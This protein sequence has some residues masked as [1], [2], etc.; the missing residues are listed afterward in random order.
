MTP[1]PG[2]P[3]CRFPLAIPRAGML[4]LAALGSG[5]A[6]A[7]SPGSIPWKNPKALSSP[8]VLTHAGDPAADQLA[9]LTTAGARH[10]VVMF[11]GPVSDMDRATLRL[12]GVTLL[13]YLGE[14]AF[15]AAVDAAQ[16]DA[17]I[18]GKVGGLV[19]AQTIPLSGKIHPLLE[20]YVDGGRGP[21]WATVGVSDD[22][23]DVAGMYVLFHSDVD[24]GDGLDA[25]EARGGVVR[26]VLNSING[27]V[28][29]LPLSQVRP[30]A[31]DDAV[32]WIEHALPQMSETNDSNRARVQ[33]D[34]AQAPPYSLTGAGVKVLVY[35]AGTARATHQDFNGRLTTHDNSGQITHATHVAGTIGGSGT[36]NPLYRGMAPGC[37]LISYGFQWSGGGIFLYSNP[38]DIEADYG[39]AINVQGAVISN[40]SIGSNTESNGFPCSIQGD[41]GVTDVLID[42]IVR[43]SL[44]GGPFRIIWAA[45]NERQG[46]NCDIE[47]Y[48]DYY[49]MAPPACAKNH[50]TV[51]ALNSNNDSMT[52][53]SSWGPTDDGR[54]K[55][56]ISAPGCEVG[57][58]GGVTS[59]SASSN[60]SYASLCGTS[61][62]SPTTC[63]VA[64]LM[65]QDYRVQ[66]PAL[67]DP[68]N[69]TLKIL[70]A[71][72]A[73][74]L[75]NMGPDYQF[76]YGS[77][78]AVNAINF[79]RTGNF[80]EDEI[81]QGG[82]ATFKVNATFA[83]PLKVTI[84]WD[85]YP[86]TANAQVALINDLD[87][88]AISPSQQV[89]YPWTLNPLN[90]SAPAVRTVRN[91]RDN[92]EQIF[93]DNP[94]TGEWTIEVIG[95]NVPEGPQPFSICASPDLTM[96]GL[97]VN[98]PGAAP[99]TLAPGVSVNVPVQIQIAGETLVPG[100]PT[101]HFRYDGGAWL[102]QPLA[103]L[104]GENY[105]ATLP[106]PVCGSTPQFYVSAAGSDS[107][108]VT[109]PA[110]APT[111]NYAPGVGSTVT[112]VSDNFENDAGWTVTNQSVTEGAWVRAIVAGSNGNR[113]DPPSDYDGS[114]R[115]WVTGNGF[116]EDLDGG[117][118]TLL[119]SNYNLSGTTNPVVSFARWMNS[120][121]GTI[122]NIQT[123][124][125]NNGGANWVLVDDVTGSGGWQ[126]KT[127][128]LA[129]FVAPS[130]QV[131]LR[132]VVSDN[133]NNSV[134]EAAI[135]ALLM[136]EFQ[137]NAVL[138]D[139]NE[140]G[141]V[142]SD[143]IASGR[144]TDSNGNG[145]PDECEE[146]TPC[147]GDLD[148]DGFVGQS[149]LGILLS[150]FG[151]TDGV[152][153]CPGDIDGDGDTDQG[154]LGALLSAFGQSCP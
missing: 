104:G 23:S 51:G 147:P 120:Y 48:G 20:E 53:F 60:T 65:L 139:C 82:V 10:I 22:G 107:G 105:Q 72:T 46:S 68:R 111:Q 136:T 89:F 56:D 145:I 129:Q 116:D 35:D 125:S 1:S 121:N 150:D 119:S 131:R 39:A 86:A 76:G 41:Y 2:R 47:G 128:D 43:G 110:N 141:I 21:S 135:D 9:D 80:F 97:R 55:P 30:L 25:V 152:G 142:D 12:G 73:I 74:D 133:P 37:T 101:L 58:D 16:Y 146:I 92:I 79:M 7:G 94:T 3:G 100:S 83:Q 40:N 93:I 88:R 85:D 26:D 106:P 112:L 64:T 15:F 122:D 61:M 148:G 14:Y 99:T 70:L 57:G 91:S 144:S 44:G 114:G 132:F 34:L 36:A 18:V 103:H 77:I 137:C 66:F 33:A 4:A 153:N 149:D 154:D 127:F 27:A 84:A 13:S 117:P 59:C 113:G 69:S 134:T 28:I 87:V 123:Y 11:S 50:I 90:P 75:G 24:L 71:H 126:V 8:T 45:G 138:A 42:N 63:G 109:N 78:R 52:S 32:Q 17:K 38:G 115:C 81:S 29:E 102:T 140:N 130:T 5:L 67:P 19:A 108:V 6:L 98:L 54:L 62:A 118:T 49:S 96:K 143:D 151:C 95:F 124:V 31:A